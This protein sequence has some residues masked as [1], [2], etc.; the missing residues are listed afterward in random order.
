MQFFLKFEYKFYQSK[1]NW[2]R[3]QFRFDTDFHCIFGF[4]WR[5]KI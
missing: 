4:A 2:L 5:A 1:K 3:R